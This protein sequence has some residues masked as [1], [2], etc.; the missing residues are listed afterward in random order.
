MNA[1]QQKL[2]EIFT[3]L[4]KFLDEHGLRYY[5]IG[6]TMLGA[7]RHGG[8]IPWDDDIDIAMPRP[9]YEKAI[10]FLRTPQDHYVIESMQ[11][12][13]KDYIY[14]FA[15]C[16]DI[17]TS[18][19]ENARTRVRRGVYVD[20]FP[21]DGIGNTREEGLKNYKKIDRL[22]MLV[23][24]RTSGYRKGRKWWKNVAVFIGGL[25]PLNVKKLTRKLDRTAARYDFD[26]M[27]YGGNLISTYRSREVMPREYFGKPTPYT[28][29]GLTVTGPEKYEEYLTHLFHD[30]R[31][32]PPEDK[33][34][35][36]HD[37]VDLKLD[38]PYMRVSDH[39]D[40]SC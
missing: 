35:S 23:A 4:T 1:L 3:F 28:F 16:Y 38:E 11:S 20:I 33:R 39:G 19:T 18:M 37:F 24:M 15:K 27:A 31:K 36:A 40:A 34:C 29:E 6:G 26:T 25:I 10:E 22:N 14:P 5:V 32:L 13:A 17:D 21:L 8:F 30:W 7:V 12:D 2:L 9:D